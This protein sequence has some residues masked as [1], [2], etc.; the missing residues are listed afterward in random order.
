MKRLLAIA[1][2]DLAAYLR[3]PAVWSLIGVIGFLV[4]GL[5]TGD[6]MLGTGT[7]FV[8]GKKAWITSEFS[9]AFAIAVLASTFYAFY[10]VIMSGLAMIRDEELKVGELLHSTPL[11]AG[12]YV[13]GK[14]AALLLLFSIVL[15]AHTFLSVFFNH[16]VSNPEADLIRGPF[17]PSAYLRPAIVFAIPTLVFFAGLALWC[18]E[19][20]RKPALVY[21]MPISFVAVIFGVLWNWSPNGLDPDINRMLM[22]AD[23]SGF[24]WLNETW[25]K[26]DRG[27]EFYNTARIGLDAGFV[28]SRLFFTALGI[29]FVGMTSRH[30]SRSLRG[31]RD[32]A[33]SAGKI[34]RR[35]SKMA[36][37]Q[38]TAVT[39]PNAPLTDLRMT[40]R[41]QGFWSGLVQTA[42]FE[43]SS[44]LRE[45]LLYAFALFIMLEALLVALL[46]T[47]AFQSPVLM[48]S[49]IFAVGTMNTLSLLICLLIM[50]YT[51][52]SMERERASGLAAIAYSTPLSSAAMLAGKAIATATVGLLIL[53][54]HLM[55][56]M[57][58]LAIQGRVEFELSPFVWIWG[59]LLVPTFI[60]WTTFVAAVRAITGQR[61]LTYSLCLGAIAL[62]VY[63]QQTG[64]LNWVTNWLVWGTV[65]W[66]DM[67]ALQLHARALVLNR[68]MMIGLAVLFAAIAVHALRRRDV[69]A[70]RLVAGLRPGPV[71]R[72][73]LR[74]SPYAALPLI[75][76]IF[77]W[78]GVAA[79]YQGEAAEREEKDYWRQ[80]LA[81]WRDAAEPSVLFVDLEVKID[82]QRRWFRTSGSY[83]LGNDHDQPLAR[84]ALSGVRHW[85]GLSWTVN[86]KSYEPE[87]RSNLYVFT[88]ATGLPPGGEMT[89]GFRFEGS[90]QDGM[91]KNG[92]DSWEFILPAGVVLNT[93]GPTFAPSIGFD[94]ERGVD[95]E[96]RY[97][98]KDYQEGFQEEILPPVL[99]S[100]RPFHARIRITTP[101]AYRANSVGVMTDES[102]R[103]GQRTVTW[104]TD[105]PVRMFNIVAGKWE[106]H[107]GEETVIYYHPGHGY[108]VEEMG[109][110][111]DAARHYYSEWFYPYPWKELK[112]SEFPGLAGYAAGWPTNIT[113]SENLGFLTRN[114]DRAD[115]V[116]TVTAHETAHQWWG[117]IVSA[118]E[119]PGSGALQEGMAH[120][121]TL[122]LAERIR[123]PRARMGMARSFEAGYNDR[124]R[125]DAERPL[126]E[127][128]GTRAGDAALRYNKA[129]WVYWMMQHLMGR[130]AALRGIRAYVTQWKDGPDYPA[131]PDF[132]DSM[133]PFAPDVEQFD[134]F[135]EQWFY[136]VV[137]P[138]YRL[139]DAR[140]QRNGESFTV[141]S[142]VENH[143]TGRMPVE[144]AAVRGERFDDDG[145]VRAE[146][147]EA[148]ET[149][150]LGPGERQ[151]ITLTTS[152][153]PE[154]LVVDPDVQVLQFRR[155]AAVAELR[156]AGRRRVPSEEIESTSRR[157][158][159]SPGAR[160]PDFRA[161]R[162]RDI[163][164]E[165]SP[166]RQTDDSS[167]PTRRW[168]TLQRPAGTV[169]PA[170]SR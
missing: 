3:G 1:R 78:M 110:V 104:E 150:I 138:E 80:N 123:G 41:P 26:Q 83:R 31:A 108:N 45:P 102:I 11:R 142:T 170:A 13:W 140:V 117:N 22:L 97:N 2:L 151:A 128:D 119:G 134:R 127:I 126:V 62:T 15:G 166:G 5:S 18:G 125:V 129:G 32:A 135:V 44:L 63:K 130:E 59:L 24:R 53:S 6:V 43:L 73:A 74:L 159:A 86:G 153:E 79:G 169:S 107:Q 8:G 103:D 56:A 30:F 144:I 65:N 49:G 131:L 141:S 154:R 132:I 50:F 76:G 100:V 42:R 113:F 133:R 137:V 9:T 149:A 84:F 52:E 37:P 94:P 148:R 48:T 75:A 158:Y 139:S 95:D 28:M 89:V 7:A 82:P 99:G 67:G 146:Y 155:G 40:S 54:A 77:L 114:D 96:N 120:F 25:L 87:N 69:D 81:T 93:F 88:P 72:R 68:C 14:F 147:M 90:V 112:L 36:T 51:V 66:T 115:A 168:G 39:I 57:V 122:L 121:S 47:G 157:S 124:R 4:W 27:V 46:R 92:G 167:L 136:D 19:R 106:V 163:Q 21:L 118:G 85:R 34:A 98:A 70:S 91:S 60:G 164:G 16:L 111:L 109:R 64:E 71:A 152:F 10:V 101:E 156:S 29:G 12:E 35:G 23:P 161:T 38:A 160:S 143:G 58:T 145:R 162:W 165:W 61:M 20:W 55:A 33:D 105:Q 17:D 116:L